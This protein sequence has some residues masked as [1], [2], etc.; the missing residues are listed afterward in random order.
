MTLNTKKTKVMI[1]N[2][3]GRHIRRDIRFGNT[4]LET[5]R[6]YKYLGFMVTPSG[7]INTGLQDLK[8]RALKAFMELKN[9]MG[10]NFRKH[11]LV[12][13]KLFKSLVEPILLYASDFWGILKLPRNN[14]IENLYMIMWKKFLAVQIQNTNVEV[15]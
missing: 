2:K 7:E 9:K 13:I 5:T 1:F 10:I 3:S 8:D 11:P 12:T 15:L 14:P 6:E 4:K